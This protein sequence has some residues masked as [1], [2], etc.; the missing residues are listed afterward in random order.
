MNYIIYRINIYSKLNQKQF[1]EKKYIQIADHDV[2]KRARGP[3]GLLSYHNPN[4]RHR[5]IPQN[6]RNTIPEAEEQVNV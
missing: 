5:E 3:K 6:C 4:P 1:N 2:E